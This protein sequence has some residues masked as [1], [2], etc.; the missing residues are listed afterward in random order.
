MAH[1]RILEAHKRPLGR[2]SDILTCILE[3]VG[4]LANKFVGIFEKQDVV[5]Q[6]LN[7]LLEASTDAQ[8]VDIVLGV[9]ILGQDHAKD[10]RVRAVV[11]HGDERQ[12]CFI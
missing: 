5:T 12:H 4:E 8:A 2:R 1:N 7:Q 11:S 3:V 10:F 6:L 9:D